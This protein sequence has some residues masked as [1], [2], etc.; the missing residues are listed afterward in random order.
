M[1]VKIE[2]YTGVEKDS[3]DL[4]EYA[5][6]SFDGDD[7][8]RGALECAQGTANNVARALG[9]LI[10]VLA[11]KRLLTDD[12]LNNILDCSLDKIIETERR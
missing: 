11:Y 12:D 1:K 8:E 7:Y 4:A 10:D 2:D 9:K 3:V 6:R 5:I